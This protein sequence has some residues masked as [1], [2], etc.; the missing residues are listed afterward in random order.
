[1]DAEHPQDIVRQAQEHLSNLARDLNEA[2][3]ALRSSSGWLRRTAQQPE[4]ELAQRMDDRLQN[5]YQSLEHLRQEIASLEQERQRLDTICDVSQVINSTLDLEELLN[6]VMDMIIQ[7]TRAERGFLMLLNEGLPGSLDEAL[8]VRVARNMDQE[9]IAGS[10]FSRSVITQVVQEGRSILTTDAQADPRFSSQASVIGFNLRS[11]LCVPLLVKEKIIGVIYVDNRIKTGLFSQEDLD[12][13]TAF[14]NQAA[15][16]LENAR[17]F[18]SVRQKVVEI[19]TMKTYMDNIFAS[20]ASGVVSTDVNGHITTFNRA[21]ETILALPSDQALGRP[22]QEVLGAI[23]DP[24]LPVLVEEVRRGA[25]RYIPYELEAEVPGRDRASLRLHLS[26]LRDA[27]DDIVGTTIVVEDLTVRRRLEAERRREEQ[28]KHRIKELFQR[29]V[30]PTVVNR[31]LSDPSQVALG[32][33]RREVTV[34]FADIRGYTTLAE[35]MPP[36]ELVALL[37]EYLALMTEAIFENEGTLDKF[38]GDAVV[39]F[40]NAPEPQAD[41]AVRAVRTAQAMQKALAEYRRRRSQEHVVGYG[42]GISTGEAVVGNIG[43]AQ[44]MNY[45]VIGDAINVAQRLQAGASPG[46]ILISENTYAYVRDQVTATSLGPITVKGRSEPV[47]VYTL[48]PEHDEH[49]FEVET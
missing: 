26:G 20:V 5:L 23:E 27:H 6:L 30:A 11:I 36:E 1:M 19:S 29:Y 4:Q 25:Q 37:N 31:L 32:G 46:Q 44:V 45:T 35:Q 28:E 13:L 12:L 40:F 38:M 16:A 42:I 10:D 33:E 49:F 18:E 34:L 43:G 24:E 17:L 21:A 8:E 2:L 15:V 22:Y 39:A 9:T 41:H 48:A 7:V 14:A 47:H 3:N